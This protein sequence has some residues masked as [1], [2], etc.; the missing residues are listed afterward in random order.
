MRPEYVSPSTLHAGAPYEYAALAPPGAPAPP[1]PAA[2]GSAGG[3][4]FFF[5]ADI[6]LLGMGNDAVP[7]ITQAPEPAPEGITPRQ[8]IIIK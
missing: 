3:Q 7:E 4:G 8:R 5:R 2:L 6:I 1:A